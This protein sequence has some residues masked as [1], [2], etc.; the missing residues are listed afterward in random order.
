LRRKERTGA[1]NPGRGGNDLAGETR[2][3]W[4]WASGVGYMSKVPRDDAVGLPMS[5]GCTAGT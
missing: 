5:P 2:A 4:P 1:A 3:P